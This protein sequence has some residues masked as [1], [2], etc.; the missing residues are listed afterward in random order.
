MQHH[1][2]ELNIEAGCEFPGCQRRAEPPGPL[3]P[4]FYPPAFPLETGTSVRVSSI[5]PQTRGHQ[6]H[7]AFRGASAQIHKPRAGCRRL[8]ITSAIAVRLR[9][10]P[11]IQHTTLQD[12]GYI[13]SGPPWSNL[14][15]FEMVPSCYKA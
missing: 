7:T 1:V 11:H 3:N 2:K 15:A 8:Y 9:C 6:R 4:P 10:R 12:N 5:S 14:D 13:V